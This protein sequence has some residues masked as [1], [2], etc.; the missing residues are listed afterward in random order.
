MKRWSIALLAVVLIL[1]PTASVFGQDGEIAFQQG[2][3]IS[4]EAMPIRAEQNI[5]AEVLAQVDPGSVVDVFEVDGI[6]AFV[7]YEGV[8][9]WAF[10]A[11]MEMR[12]AQVML[13]GGV[14]S[15]VLAVR[16]E[17]S[18]SA[19]TVATVEGG[20]QVGVLVL[21]MDGTWAYVYTGEALGWTFVNDLELSEDTFYVDNFLKDAAVVASDVLAVRAEP[22]I[23]AD[24][25]FTV[26]HDEM[27]YVLYE[28]G[29]FSYVLYDHETGWAFSADLDVTQPRA[30]ATGVPTALRVNFRS[31][32][33]TSDDYNI[34]T[35]LPEGAEVLLLG[36]TEDG[37]WLQ[38]RFDG[39][40]GWVSTEL[41]ETEYD[42]TMLPVTG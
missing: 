21:D 18:I 2:V 5:S 36:Q 23:S 34:I 39:E 30:Y 15:D 9:G 26:E 32:P 11:D 41:I 38:I 27:V 16:T 31:E 7:S 14:L 25:L 6:W 4:T 37:T 24:V 29:I 28:E 19:D 8:E 20:E 33:D 22:S 3:V 13:S 35:Q 10:A 1:L 42:V 40:M 17:Q 12:D